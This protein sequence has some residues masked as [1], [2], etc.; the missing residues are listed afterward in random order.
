MGTSI[1]L[2]KIL[3]IPIGINYS[4][5]FVFL[6]FIYL[7]SQQFADRFPDLPLAQRWFFASLT[8]VFFFLSVLAHE[9]SHSL[10]AV[11][12]GIP[13]IGITLFIFGG[14]SLLAHEAR[15]PLT[16]FIV[17]IVGPL[18][19]ILLGLVLLSLWD[20]T[21]GLNSPLS[22]MLFTLFVI[23]FSLGIFNLLPGFPL[24]GGRVLRSVVWAITGSY[25]KATQ[26]AARGGQVIGG[27]MVVVGIGLAASGL[28]QLIW[29]SLIG[30]FLVSAATVSYRQERK[31][32]SLRHYRVSDAMTTDW[33]TLP[34]ETSLTSPLV[35]QG[36]S[37]GE[38]FVG[39]LIDG[40][41]K[42]IVTRRQ[43]AQAV[44]GAWSYT[45]LAQVMR[46]LTDLPL[47]E[48]SEAIFDLAERM[49]SEGQDRVVVAS[50][51]ALLG[52]LS[53]AQA[54]RFVKSP[55]PPKLKT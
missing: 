36:L 5:I 37:G 26:I 35:A 12:R 55:K 24:D 48:P 38:D 15:R 20:L 3:G 4:W 13:V 7:M 42:G 39:V 18:T 49:D 17:A 27:L 28:Y 34:G 6:L 52:L 31:R 16:E 25:W 30:G 40:R 44:R 32:E 33:R 2:G 47:T 19:S 1:R 8:T 54:Q 14:V 22:A 9:L 41:M 11:R 29:M 51:G 46:P 43:L 53:R 23:N 21:Q 45:N 50:N 10:V